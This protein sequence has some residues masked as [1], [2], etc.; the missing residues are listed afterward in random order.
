V[1]A[2]FRVLGPLECQVADKTIR[3]SGAKQQTVLGMLLLGMERPVPL[4]RLID[5]VWGD[6]APPTATKQIRNAVSDLRQVLACAGVT[7]RVAGDGYQ[8]DRAGAAFDLE[9]FTRRV[10]LAEAETDAVRAAEALRAALAL[11]RG[12]AL[13]GLTSSVLRSQMAG[14]EELRLAA[15]E[16]CVNLELA[17][18]KH[19]SL[20]GELTTAVAEDP[21]RERLV[22][23]LMIALCRSGSR[24]KALRVFDTTR[25]LLRDELG[26]DPEPQLQD[27]NLRI[28]VSDLP[29]TLALTRG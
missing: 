7:I 23:Q 28:V 20:V 29:D 15:L 16:E 10:E 25:R 8:L 12:P 27:L 2:I 5:A 14:I 3:L 26:V 13:A 21:F 1:S 6:S 17:Q 24:A 11:W 9:D 18:G 22:A 19:V 4:S